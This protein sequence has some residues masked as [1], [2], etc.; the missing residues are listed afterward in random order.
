MKNT[1]SFNTKFGRIYATE[2]NNKITKIQFCRK[3]ELGKKSKNLKNIK[4]KIISFFQKK[5]N[6]LDA[7]I[8]FNGNPIQKKIW[9]ELKKVKKGKV[10]TYGEIAK[11]L[12]ISPR[13][14]GRVCGENNHLLVVPCHRIIRSDKTLGG[15]SSPG[16]I[17]L[18]R[19]LLEFEG[20]FI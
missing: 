12:K 3:K 17:K 5:T 14:V 4:K 16:G 7:K 2:I 10:K 9:R 11:K 13:Y 20:I 1:I 18:K 6:K 15:F 8:L 19:K